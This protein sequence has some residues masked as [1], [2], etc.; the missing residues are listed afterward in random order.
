MQLRRMVGL[1]VPLAFTVRVILELNMTRKPNAIPVGPNLVHAGGAG[2]IAGA[3]TDLTLWHAPLSRSARILWL[4]E[5]I[6]CAYRLETL[7]SSR[8]LGRGAA[9]STPAGTARWRT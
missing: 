6:G 1:T 9:S 5:E 2:C 7:P 4:L 8:T 3:M